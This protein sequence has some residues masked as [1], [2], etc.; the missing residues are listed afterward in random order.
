MIYSGS[1][2]MD[3]AAI[4]PNWISIWLFDLTAAIEIDTLEPRGIDICR[5][6]RFVSSNS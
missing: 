3:F 6:L 5:E 1:F 4:S 2:Q